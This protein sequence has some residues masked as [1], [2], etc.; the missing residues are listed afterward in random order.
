M[1]TSLRSDP[2]KYGRL[3]ERLR[4][5][6]MIEYRRNGK[7]RC[8]LFAVHKKA[9]KQRL[10]VDARL[11]NCCFTESS[12]VSLCSGATLGAICME[13]GEQLFVG[14]VDIENAFYGM[15][16]PEELVPFFC[17][18]RVKARHTQYGAEALDNILDDTWLYPHFR[19]IPMGSLPAFARTG[20]R[21]SSGPSAAHALAGQGAGTAGGG[22]CFG[23]RTV[24]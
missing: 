17:L 16:L 10:I 24:R 4:S 19:V 8:G 13:E 9:G 3:L 15:L 5:A 18:P 2:A 21:S 14:Q 12:P 23:S 7:P 11:A 1:D 6:G 20:G 22:R